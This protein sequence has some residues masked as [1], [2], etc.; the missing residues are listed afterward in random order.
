MAFKMEHSLH[1]IDRVIRTY[2]VETGQIIEEGEFV[3]MSPGAVLTVRRGLTN[4]ALLGISNTRGVVT[5][6]AAGTVT[7]DVIITTGDQLLRVE[8]LL[9]ADAICV[10]GQ[11][12]DL[13]LNAISCAAAAN[14]DFTIWSHDANLNFIVVKPDNTEY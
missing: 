2:V 5:G 7:V 8:Q 11:R 14:N 10:P 4:N 9:L 12:L 13:A 3:M 6:V 1:D